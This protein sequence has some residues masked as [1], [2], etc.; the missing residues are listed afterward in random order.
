MS[1]LPKHITF[2]LQNHGAPGQRPD[3]L[4]G[5]YAPVYR[6]SKCNFEKLKDINQN[7][8]VERKNQNLKLM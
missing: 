4:L 1:K 5:T 3:R 6:E 8:F 7:Q 2:G